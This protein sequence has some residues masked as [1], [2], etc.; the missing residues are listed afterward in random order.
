MLPRFIL[1][2]D[3]ISAVYSL[4]HRSVNQTEPERLT[5]PKL[6]DNRS[7]ATIQRDITD[8]LDYQIDLGG[9]D[10]KCSILIG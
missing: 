4:N 10:R 6:P 1:L 3:L 5:K 9:Y 8:Y 2:Y 7:P